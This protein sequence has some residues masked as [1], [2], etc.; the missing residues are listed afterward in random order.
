MKTLHEQTLDD[1]RELAAQRDSLS[2]QLAAVKA[3]L[4]AAEKRAAEDLRQHASLCGEIEEL[5]SELDTTRGLLRE[6]LD[7]EAG[8]YHGLPVPLS[9]RISAYLATSPSGQPVPRPKCA[10]WKEMEPDERE[11]LD[12]RTFCD[13]E[14]S[15]AS[16]RPC[17]RGMCATGDDWCEP[18][19]SAV[20]SDPLD[21][22]TKRLDTLEL[23][24]RTTVSCEGAVIQRI[25]ELSAKV[26]ALET[27][28]D[29]SNPMC[30]LHGDFGSAA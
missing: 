2:T 26:A 6:A 5:G 8:D 19:D 10:G 11:G 20:A 27:R 25:D 28:R 9:N 13:A 14:E 18:A 16:G 23:N 17:P 3:E 22:V 24:M 4:G 29:A 1:I 21:E 15:S 7:A 30:C 12:E